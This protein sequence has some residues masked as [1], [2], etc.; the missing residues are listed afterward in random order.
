MLAVAQLV[1]SLWDKEEEETGHILQSLNLSEPHR[2]L[3]KKGICSYSLHEQGALHQSDI[4]AHPS[5][6]AFEEYVSPQI[7]KVCYL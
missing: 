2:E 7:V 1:S 4:S 6:S 3:V 5:A